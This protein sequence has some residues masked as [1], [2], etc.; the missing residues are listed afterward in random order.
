[1]SAQKYRVAKKCACVC[2]ARNNKHFATIRL[3]DN[4][5]FLLTTKSLLLSLGNTTYAISTCSLCQA[6][7]SATNASHIVHYVSHTRS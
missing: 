3:N 2:R 6:Q 1:M 5:F 7:P 4:S